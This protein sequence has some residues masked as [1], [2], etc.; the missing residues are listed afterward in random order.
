MNE[1]NSNWH[2]IL[3]EYK[4][5]PSSW[6]RLKTLSYLINKLIIIIKLMSFDIYGKLQ[7]TDVNKIWKLIARP[8]IVVV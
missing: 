6:M 3:H 2:L 4:R 1:I 5:L 8:L 7:E